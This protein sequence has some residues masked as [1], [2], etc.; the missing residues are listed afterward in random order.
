MCRFVFLGLEPRIYPNSQHGKWS[1]QA[2]SKRRRSLIKTATLINGRFTL[3]L[4]SSSRPSEARA[5]IGE[6][7]ISQQGIGHPGPGSARGFVRGDGGELVRTRLFDQERGAS[8][9]KQ[10]RAADAAPFRLS[11]TVVIRCNRRGRRSWNSSG[12]PFAPEGPEPSGQRLPD[13]RCFRCEVPGSPGLHRG[14]QCR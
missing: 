5:G 14:C 4:R 10:K 6:P 7:L 1:G 3:S 11:V 8:I 13:R 2:R 12:G 9:P